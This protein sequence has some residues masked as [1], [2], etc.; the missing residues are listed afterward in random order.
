MLPPFNSRTPPRGSGDRHAERR[1]QGHPCRDPDT[2][3]GTRSRW[4]AKLEALYYI[5][6]VDSDRAQM[7]VLDFSCQVAAEGSM[8]CAGLSYAM[9]VDFGP[10]S[11]LTFYDDYTHFRKSGSR[12]Q[13]S[14]QHV[15]GCTITVG[16]FC[17]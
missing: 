6:G 11:K 10:I 14:Q 3:K 4:N 13:D 2:G 17:T 1:D 9:S 16:G 7:G 8:Y 12:F 15:L 5:F